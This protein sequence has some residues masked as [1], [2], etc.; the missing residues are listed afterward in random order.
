[1]NMADQMHRDATRPDDQRIGNNPDPRPAIAAELWPRFQEGSCEHNDEHTDLCHRTDSRFVVGGEL[2]QPWA[3]SGE[4]AERRR[5]QRR[6]NQALASWRSVS[7]S[8]DEATIT[9]SQRGV[10]IKQR[11]LVSIVTSSETA[12]FP[13]ALRV[14]T[15]AAA[16][17]Q[18]TVAAIIRPIARSSWSCRPINGHAIKG[19]SP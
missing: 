10:N 15:D 14:Q 13:P 11:P 2:P 6:D 19:V 4:L 9:L 12:S 17:V 18:G 7:N 5:D 3:Q 1:M 8:N 16:I